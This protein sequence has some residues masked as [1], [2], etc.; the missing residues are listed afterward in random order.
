MGLSVLLHR[1]VVSLQVMDELLP[2]KVYP[3]SQLYV[4]MLVVPGLYEIILLAVWGRELWGYTL[5]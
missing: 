4:A 3:V 1:I 2:V 5:L